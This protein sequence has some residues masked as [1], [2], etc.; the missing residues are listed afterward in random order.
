MENGR[1]KEALLNFILPLSII[2]IIE[3][4]ENFLQTMKNVR[5]KKKESLPSI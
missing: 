4:K 3:I 5:A 1:V 2:I